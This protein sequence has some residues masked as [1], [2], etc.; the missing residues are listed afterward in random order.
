MIKEEGLSSETKTSREYQN[1]RNGEPYGSIY[2]DTV[3]LDTRNKIVYQDGPSHDRTGATF[4]KTCTHTWMSNVPV[5]FRYRTWHTNFPRDTLYE[6]RAYYPEGYTALR[7]MAASAVTGLS[8]KSAAEMLHAAQYAMEGRLNQTL[9]PI[10]DLV[11]LVRKVDGLG[12]IDALFTSILAPF[13]TKPKT[14]GDL[15]KKGLRR[16]FGPKVWVPDAVADDH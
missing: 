7:N 5:P 4:W 3:K 12:S 6:Y 8:P 16:R 11:Q 1:I 9:L 10:T 14:F 13:R 2:R 15:V